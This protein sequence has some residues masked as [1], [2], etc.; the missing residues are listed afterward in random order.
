MAD[1]EKTNQDSLPEKGQTSEKETTPSQPQTYTQEQLDKIVE[2]TIR[3][4]HAKLDKQI[5]S[6]TKER[7][8]IKVQ[9]EKAVSEATAIKE[10]TQGKIAE[11]ESDLEE[12]VKGDAD[13]ADVQKLKKALRDEKSQLA[14]DAKVEKEAIAAEKEAL[15]KERE[16]W[17]ETVTKAQETVF[18]QDVIDIA[19]EYAGDDIKKSIEYSD[20]LKTLC[21]KAGIKTKE[22]AKEMAEVLWKKSE[23]KSKEEPMV[24]DSGVSKGGGDVTEEKRLKSRYPNTNF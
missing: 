21:D 13:A 5:D 18:E 23:E 3:E 10:E 14:K 24:A 9:L 17:A 16:E 2:A 12:A 1:E 19:G 4:R 20:T 11:L 8:G 7:D 15:T 22:G 6:L